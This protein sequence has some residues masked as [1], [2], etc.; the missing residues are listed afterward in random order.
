[1]PSNILI[2]REM[3]NLE[4]IIAYEKYT[5]SITKD[6]STCRTSTACH[7]VTIQQVTANSRPPLMSVV[8]QLESL[9]KQKTKTN[10]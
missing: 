7:D 3:S 1:M 5:R 4:K 10:K 9:K 8:L 6:R 2:L